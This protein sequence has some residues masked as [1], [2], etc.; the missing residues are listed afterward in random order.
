MKIH[1]L[2]EQFWVVT[3]PSPFSTTEDVLFACTFPR[4]IHQVRGGLKEDD[5]VGIYADEHEASKGCRP[6]AGDISRAP[7]DAVFVEVTV[8]MMAKPDHEEMAAK[9]LARAAVEAV[10]NAVRQAE[11]MGYSHHLHEQVSLGVGTVML[12]N[13]SVAIDTSSQAVSCR[14]NNQ[15]NP[16]TEP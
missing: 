4:L 12:Q 7:Q 10:Q 8:N 5:I 1:G 15:K 16:G 3:K 13:L 9:E 2:P 6:A 11:E 14:P